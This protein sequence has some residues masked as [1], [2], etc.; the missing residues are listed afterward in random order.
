MTTP[1]ELAA[2]RAAYQRNQQAPTPT[3]VREETDPGPEDDTA[4]VPLDDV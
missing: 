1:D 4:R 2:A 3:T